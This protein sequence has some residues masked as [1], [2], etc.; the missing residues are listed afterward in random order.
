MTGSRFCGSLEPFASQE[1]VK[2][3]ETRRESKRQRLTEESPRADRLPAQSLPRSITWTDLREGRDIIDNDRA[4]LPRFFST[5]R[6]RSAPSPRW[7]CFELLVTACGFC[8]KSGVRPRTAVR[9][10]RT[11]PWTSLSCGR[12]LGIFFTRSALACDS[13]SSR[14]R[15]LLPFSAEGLGRGTFYL[16]GKYRGNPSRD[17]ITT[18]GESFDWVTKLG[19]RRDRSMDT[20]ETESSM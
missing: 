17:F 20:S 5:S 3:V 18:P 11:A 4:R 1:T 12:A 14:D 13:F 15:V 10:W 7:H 8:L 9:R 16:I 6:S 19:S 2:I